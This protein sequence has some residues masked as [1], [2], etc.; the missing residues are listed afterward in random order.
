MNEKIR[1][2]LKWVR[3]EVPELLGI[4]SEEEYS[5]DDN[6]GTACQM[7]LE[8][9]LLLDPP[10]TH[11]PEPLMPVLLELN[12]IAPEQGWTW[13]PDPDR[14]AA[15]SGATEV[16]VE[17]ETSG[18]TRRAAY[19]WT[20]VTIGPDG[21][22]T[23]EDPPPAVDEVFTSRMPHLAARRAAIEDYTAVISYSP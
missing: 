21:A 19:T 10:I 22:L 23:P 11:C 3:D 4:D 18:L 20:V 16:Y 12:R 9:S 8:S 15:I 13:E 1:K 5:P 14:L 7:Q 6:L 2:I 17:C